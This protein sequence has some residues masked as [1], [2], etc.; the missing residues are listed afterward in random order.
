[1]SYLLIVDRSVW[2]SRTHS[3][4][5]HEVALKQF[6]QLR[7]VVLAGGVGV[8]GGRVV[9]RQVTFYKQKRMN[10]NCKFKMKIT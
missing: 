2:T 5:P 10:F 8:Q 9:E 3:I 4:G 1:M 6:H 7:V